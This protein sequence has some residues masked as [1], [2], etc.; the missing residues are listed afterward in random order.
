MLGSDVKWTM[1][2]TAYLLH[3]SALHFDSFNLYT[4][5]LKINQKRKN[6]KG[7][8]KKLTT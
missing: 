7:N 3:F 1:R 8:K 6:L 5:F 2:N 4:I